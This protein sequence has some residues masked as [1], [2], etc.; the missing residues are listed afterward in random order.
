[1]ARRIVTARAHGPTRRHHG[2][3]DVRPG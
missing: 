2:R 3:R 1:M